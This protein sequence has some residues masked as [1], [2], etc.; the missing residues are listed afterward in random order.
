MT[1]ENNRVAEHFDAWWKESFPHAP[2][3][4]QTRAN[5]IAFGTELER[6][7]YRDLFPADNQ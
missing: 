2:C 1:Q 3:N 5:F 4:P 7:W 6:R